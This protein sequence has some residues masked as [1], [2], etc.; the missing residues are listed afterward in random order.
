MGDATTVEQGAN[1]APKPTVLVM[2]GTGRLSSVLEPGDAWA[3]GSGGP[4]VRASDMWPGAGGKA[5][6]ALIRRAI[7]ARRSQVS[8][9]DLI[10]RLPDMECLC[11]PQGRD[12]ALLVIRDLSG[13]AADLERMRRLA[14]EDP[15]TGLPNRQQ[16]F[17][18]LEKVVGIQGL[19]EGRSAVLSVHLGRIEDNVPGLSSFQQDALLREVAARLTTQVR[20]SNSD[21]EDDMERVTVI[22][23]TDY[24]QFSMILPDIEAGTD[25]ESVA[26][27][28]V[29]A[30]A[31]AIP[32]GD[33]SVLV[34]PAIGVA[35]Y[36]QDGE[37][38]QTLFDNALVAMEAAR[39]D[40]VPGYQ[41]HSGT[42]RLRA[43]QRQDLALE[44]KSALDRGAFSLNYL[45]IVDA[46]TS[47]PVAIEALVRWPSALLGERSVSRLVN[48]AE[49]TGLIVPI[50]EWV[51]HQSLALIAAARTAGSNARLA[52]N[53]SPQELSRPDLPDRVFAIAQE[54]GL[55]SDVL[56]FEITESTL[57]RDAANGFPRV[58]ALRAIGATVVLDGFG[59]GTSSVAALSRSPIDGLKIDRSIVRDVVTSDAAAAACSAAAA[60]GKELG[61][62]LIA[63]GIETSEQAAALAGMGCEQLQ[64]FLFSRPVDS[65]TVL[66]LGPTSVTTQVAD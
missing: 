38:A 1:S 17:E 37:D 4:S 21:L 5:V 66:E 60:M 27:R 58:K 39:N 56:E 45:P 25:A 20:G 46:V 33:R 64:G 43:L 53:I 65:H 8:R 54:Y 40:N 19:R 24:R 59:A 32:V 55:D 51:L 41:M 6:G 11:V 57:A 10:P 29:G 22:G 34:S 23:R 15:T 61:L 18:D 47:K 2:T 9:V 49:R 3:A 44:L 13:G 48:I 16:F 28:I 62:R 31:Q 52:V 36:P 42:M 30:L 63:V 26:E 50:G 14:F 7:K 12:A 35:L